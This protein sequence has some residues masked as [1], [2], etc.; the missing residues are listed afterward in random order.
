[1][2]GF[3]IK[4]K[5]NIFLFLKKCKQEGS[6]VKIH[7]LIFCSIL[8]VTNTA[9]SMKIVKKNSDDN[10]KNNLTCINQWN[11]LGIPT[12]Y[13]KL[14]SPEQTNILEKIFKTKPLFFTGDIGCYH[15]YYLL[16]SSK[17]YKKFLTLPIKLRQCLINAPQPHKKYYYKQMNY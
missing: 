6:F 1:M 8:F 12:E 3:Q 4:R 11:A 5:N 7:V 16:S 14:L 10:F 17:D 9:H 2:L 15:G 13:Q